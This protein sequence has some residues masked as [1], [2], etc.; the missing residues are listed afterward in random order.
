MTS[1]V[2]RDTVLRMALACMAVDPT[3]RLSASQRAWALALPQRD[4]PLTARE[5][6]RLLSLVLPW[7]DKQGCRPGMIE[8]LC[9]G[10]ADANGV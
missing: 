7:M 5:R 6:Q 2:V 1:S 3:S 10:M 9:G 8:N 4:A